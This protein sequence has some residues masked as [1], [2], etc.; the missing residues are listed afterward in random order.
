[1][2]G[3]KLSRLR[4]RIADHLQAI[5]GLF[6][7]PTKITIVIRTPELA[8]GGVLVSDDDYDLAIGE[9]QRLREKNPV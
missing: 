7:T 2:A 8:D 9:I 4:S 1:M 3:E 5:D 6:T